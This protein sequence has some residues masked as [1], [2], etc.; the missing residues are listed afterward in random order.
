[1]ASDSAKPSA[2][3]TAITIWPTSNNSSKK[4]KTA[5]IDSSPQTASSPWMDT[6]PNCP[7]SANWPIA[8][9]PPSWSMT[10]TPS[11]SSEAPEKVPPNTSMWPAGSTSSP[12]PSEKHSAVPPAATPAVANHSST[13]CDSAPDPTCSQIHSLHPS[14][15]PLSKLLNSSANPISC[16]HSCAKTP[17]TS[18]LP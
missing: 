18:A 17:L 14:P 16:A 8:G 12:V 5:A 2:I 7:I 9:T 1:M 11:A 10:H 3:A 6:S 15:P 13:C 4:L